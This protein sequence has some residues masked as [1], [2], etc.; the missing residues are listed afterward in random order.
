[1]HASKNAREKK[2]KHTQN[3]NGYARRNDM[4][5]YMLCDSGSIHIV[6]SLAG[7]RGIT[8]PMPCFVSHSVLIFFSSAQKT[9]EIIRKRRRNMQRNKYCYSKVNSI[10]CISVVRWGA[11]YTLVIFAL[12]ANNFMSDLL[13]GQ[14]AS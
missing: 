7:L 12:S 13:N 10:I 14:P 8:L 9:L 6:L 11:F 4:Y 3:S 2:K 5:K 1:M